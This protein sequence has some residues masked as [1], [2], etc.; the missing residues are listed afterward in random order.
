[1][2]KK[3]SVLTRQV[4]GF[5]IVIVGGILG[6]FF[7]YVGAGGIIIAVGLAIASGLK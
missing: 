4:I 2:D 6:S 7:H 1:M 5:S 3:A